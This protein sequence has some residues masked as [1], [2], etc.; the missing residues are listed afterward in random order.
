MA[1]FQMVLKERE[2]M[3]DSFRNCMH[4]PLG[5]VQAEFESCNHWTI[6]NPE[7]TEKSLCSGLRNILL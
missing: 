4:C 3:C 2:R 1:E 6:E 5:K 7:E